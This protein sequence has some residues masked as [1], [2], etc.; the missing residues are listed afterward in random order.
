M[1][2]PDQEALYAVTKSKIVEM[3]KSGKYQP[4][5]KLPTEAEFCNMFDVSRTTIRIALQQLELEGRIYRRQGKGTFVSRSKIEQSLTTSNKGFAEQMIDQGLEPETIVI[6]LQVQ[7]A[8]QAMAQAL[9][10]QEKDP[11]TKLVRLRSASQEPLQYVESYIPWKIAPGLNKEESSGSLF[12]LLKSKYHVTVGK[13]IE[14]VEPILA[15]ETISGHLN[16][17]VGT[18]CLAVETITLS[19]DHIPIEY[20]FAVFRGDRSKFVVERIYGE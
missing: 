4:D 5:E 11:L 9:N 2:N 1:K 3:I 16:I 15:D 14:T 10:L 17:S 6:D 19:N 20:S 12:Q 8:S 18:P 7:P 13:T